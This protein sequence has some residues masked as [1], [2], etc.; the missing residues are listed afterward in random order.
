[1]TDDPWAAFTKKPSVSN[2]TDD[3]WASFTSKPT[4]NVQSPKEQSYSKDLAYGLENDILRGSSNTL[5]QYGY[6]NAAIAL[7]KTADL[8]HKAAGLDAYSPDGGDKSLGGRVSNIGHTLAQG[9]PGMAQDIAAGAAGAAMGG[10]L[11]PVTGLMGFGG[12]YALRHL[13]EVQDRIRESAGKGPDSELTTGEQLRAGGTLLADTL[14]NRFGVGKVLKPGPVKAVG[15]KAAPEI[16]AKTAEGITT[17]AK[18]GAGQTVLDSVALD[19]KLPSFSDLAVSGLTGAAAGAVGGI[20]NV[21]KESLRAARFKELGNLDPQSRI[22]VTNVLDK[23]KGDFNATKQYHL[24]EINKA[25]KDLDSV[26]QDYIDKEVIAFKNGQRVDPEKLAEVTKVDP[27]AGRALQNL[28]TLSAMQG[29]NNGGLSGTGFGRMVEPFGSK[30]TNVM[31]LGSIGTLMFGHHLPYLGAASPYIAGGLLAGQGLG[32]G[33]TRGLDRLS[34]ASNPSKVIIDKF[35]GDPSSTTS[36]VQARTK[37]NNLAN[38]RRQ[39]RTTADLLSASEELSKAKAS[40]KDTKDTIKA[41]N[42]LTRLKTQFQ[43]AAANDARVEQK[44]QERA[45]NNFWKEQRERL[46]IRTKSDI[47]ASEYLGQDLGANQNVPLPEL[48]SSDTSLALKLASLKQQLQ[49]KRMTQLGKQANIMRNSQALAERQATAEQAATDQA[50]LRQVNLM[51]NSQTT[52]QARQDALLRNVGQQNR[53]RI[54]SESRPFDEMVSDPGVF[55][56]N[57]AL[58]RDAFAA[59]EQAQAAAEAEAAANT[60]REYNIDDTDWGPSTSVKDRPKDVQALF[61]A[62]KALLKIR[63]KL[64]RQEKRKQDAEDRKAKQE[65]AKKDRDAKKL[66]DDETKAKAAKIVRD[67]EKKTEEAAK[68]ADPEFYTFKYR[69]QQIRVPAESIEAPKQF[70]QSFKEKTDRRLDMLADAKALTED[71]KVHKILDQLAKD[72]TD[73]TNDP[74]LAYDA[75]EDVV[76][77]NRIPQNIKNNLLDNWD[78]V[79]RT[80]ATK[81]RSQ[82]NTE[83]V[84]D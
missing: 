71:K 28:D 44:V 81:R 78:S 22:D 21:F 35:G 68:D 43:T 55:R 11:A 67:A 61:D 76:N 69:G 60:P 17:G 13:G 1:M 49:D 23:Y 50:L 4:E 84:D 10:P 39:L 7:T 51:R 32:Y 16:A 47:P 8:V 12:S 58:A 31:D 29:M 36:V 27:V 82:T 62:N 37:A 63:E 41:E 64:Q 83:D 19:Q 54:A 77:D 3:P 80:W 25:K 24:D 73:T 52:E 30:F 56:A 34:G 14:L 40:E 20:P 46:A 38:T 42:A 45:D 2:N 6:P 70:E 33:I 26:T 48:V 74:S 75:L 53:I 5:N 59:Q 65:Q 18:I 72:W 15:L 9:A 66:K 79:K 57:Q